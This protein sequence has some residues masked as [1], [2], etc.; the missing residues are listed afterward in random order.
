MKDI[1]IQD[2][3][4]T[5]K[6][7]LTD[8]DK[9]TFIENW[10]ENETWEISFTIVKTKFNEL[11]FDLV[12]Y[13]NS[14]FFNGQEFI[15]KQ[16]GVSAEGAAITKTVT[17]THIYYTMQDGFQYDTITGTRSI[18]Q[19]LAHVFEPD[20]RGFTWNVVDPNKKFLPVEQEN[21]GN[22][23]YLKLVEEILK[24]YDAIVIPDNKN[25]TFFPR[26]EYGKKTEEQIRYK[27]NTDSVKFD[28]D[29]LNLKTQIKGFGKKKE[30][31]TYYFTPITYT[32]KQSEKWGI[33]VQSP[34][35]DD[36]YTVSGNMLERL[37]T[38]LQDYPTITGTVTM[39]WRVEP[40]KGDYVAFVYEPLG[41]NTYIQVVGIK[42]YPAIPNKPPEITLS[43]TKKTM[44][45]IL[46][47][48]T[49]KG[50][51]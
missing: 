24:D 14:V 9:S 10:Q 17:A 49:K 1:F 29:T 21:F 36:R 23:N 50:V 46:A 22:G 8:Y 40:N 16:M 34:V 41:V 13:E 51:V 2:Y 45:A 7:I 4:K 11:A 33:R 5:K 25:L 26:S 37:K 30:D 19:L 28:I 15:V 31:D 44:T 48:M 3:E 27:Y 35:S 39:K 42:T 18:N 38:D 47:E 32:S 12:D 6:E 20:N 43:N